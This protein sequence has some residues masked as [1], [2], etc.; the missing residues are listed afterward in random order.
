MQSRQKF[1]KFAYRAF[2]EKSAHKNY[3][4][5]EKLQAKWVSDICE[6]SEG[7]LQEVN[8]A[9]TCTFLIYLHFRIVNRIY[10][11]NKYL[12]NIQVIKGNNCTFCESAIETIY[13]LFWQCPITQIFIKEVLS[14]LK[15]KYNTIISVNAVNWFMLKGLANIEVLV[16][17]LSKSCIHK[18]RLK[19]TKPSVELMIRILRLEATKEYHV[20]KISNKVVEFERKWG[21]LKKLLN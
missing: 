19:A 12:F 6:F 3:D 20:A 13:H 1:S 4:S 5:N 7:T 11:T 16:V 18:A 15:T 14:H 8:K 10:A 17:T 2:V 21:E 9:T